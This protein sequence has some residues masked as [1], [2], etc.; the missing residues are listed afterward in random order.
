M[1]LSEWEKFL[2]FIKRW[3]LLFVPLFIIL[4]SFVIARAIMGLSFMFSSEE[5]YW[6]ILYYGSFFVFGYIYLANFKSTE[7]INRHHVF[8]TVLSILIPITLFSWRQVQSGNEKLLQSEVVLK[9]EN[10]R[11]IEQLR[12]IV[13][14]NED[15]ATIYWMDFSTRAYKE[16]WDYIHLNQS[17]DCKN[18]YATLTLQLDALNKINETRRALVLIPNDF[19]SQFLLGASLTIPMLNEIVS[20]CQRI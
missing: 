12:L 1:F 19:H 6:F 20:K 10:S 9:E 11:N 2:T 18:L 5:F 17:Q 7:W 14:G 4:L 15:P 16:K 13:E 8:I 3:E